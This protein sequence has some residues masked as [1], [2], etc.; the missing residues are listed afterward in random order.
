MGLPE[1]L[2][3]FK[4]VGEFGTQGPAPDEHPPVTPLDGLAANAGT[5]GPLGAAVGQWADGWWS[6]ALKVPA[7]ASRVG[8][9]ITPQ[10]VVVHTTDMLPNDW[11]AL[12][13][14]WARKPGQCA[15][16]FNIGRSPLQGVVQHVSVTRNANHAGGATRNGKPMHGWWVTEGGKFIHPNTIA[17]GIELH[18]AGMLKWKPGAVGRVALYNDSDSHRMVE[19]TGDDLYVDDLNRPWHVI[20]QYQLDRLGELL[21]ALKA[22]L[23]S[24]AEGT[25]PQA[26]AAYI[27]DRSYWDT[28]AALPTRDTLVGHW[29]LDPV[30]KTDPGPQGM[31]ALEEIAQ[32]EGYR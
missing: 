2:S 15:A 12:E 18:C 26:D 14:A 16:H 25:K 19:F 11:V 24:L 20:T 7:H 27:K 6:G 31:Q 1:W 23:K 4:S 9:V 30:N 17:I 28:S 8:G 10:T 21:H 3:W 22:V 13:A 29:S 32:K 5:A